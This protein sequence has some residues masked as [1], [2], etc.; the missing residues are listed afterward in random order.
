M[1]NVVGGSPKDLRVVF[2]KTQCLIASMMQQSADPAGGMVVIYPERRITRRLIADRT[3]PVLFFKHALVVAGQHVVVV[4]QKPLAVL[5]G[6]R[7]VLPPPRRTFDIAAGSAL[8]TPWWEAV[9]RL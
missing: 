4:L 2:E 7:W 8:T 1:F 6:G 5:L 9:V 3:E